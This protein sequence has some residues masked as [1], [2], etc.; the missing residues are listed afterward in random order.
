MMEF[1]RF[2]FSDAAVFWGIVILFL[3]AAHYLVEMVKA[4]R[5]ASEEFC[6]ADGEKIGKI[7][8]ETPILSVLSRRPTSLY[9]LRKCV[10]HSVG[11]FYCA[12]DRLETQG[13]I[14][15]TGE[16]FERNGHAYR[17]FELTGE[18]AAKVELK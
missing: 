12:I 9:H 17:I 6:A 10:G 7:S 2:L 18:G 14:R 8:L 5:G 1:L 13:L 16:T 15:A 4:L 11:G 3:L